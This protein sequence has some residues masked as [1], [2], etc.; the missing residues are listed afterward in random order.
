MLLSGR[1]SQSVRRTDQYGDAR[2]LT[3][4]I[5]EE[6]ARIYLVLR[7]YRM[8][9]RNFRSPY[10]EIDLIAMHRGDLVFL[11]V[12]TRSSE[13]MGHPAESVTAHKQR[14]IIK[15]AQFY[16]NKNRLHGMSCRFD[17]I[18]ILF[19]PG[20]LPDIQLF[21]N[22]FEENQFMRRQGP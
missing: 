9:V 2:I 11:E 7:G 20:V 19:R 14:Q 16:I 6:I 22:A 8:L 18:T 3:G 4:Q 21:E 15:N 5:G 1:L 12:R 17:V 13:A 10:G